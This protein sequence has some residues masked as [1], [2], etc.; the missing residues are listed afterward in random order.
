MHFDLTALR[1]ESAPFRLTQ[2]ITLNLE[3]WVRQTILEEI[4]RAA[5]GYEAIYRQN[6]RIERTGPLAFNIVFS[7]TGSNGEP[8]AGV[9]LERGTKPHKIRS[10]YKLFLRWF[11]QTA[12]AKFFPQFNKVR[13]NIQQVH[14]AKE[15]NHPGTTGLQAMSIGAQYGMPKLMTKIIAETNRFLQ[16]TRMS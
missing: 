12:A 7:Y 10:R 14:F 2:Y 15:V 11:T 4:V 9:F 1:L 3:N 16:E 5:H 6:L 13:G 8:L